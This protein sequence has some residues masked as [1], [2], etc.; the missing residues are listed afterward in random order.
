MKEI[1]SAFGSE[2]FRPLVT[3][4]LPGALAASSWVVACLWR[5]DSLRSLADANRA[6]SAA[7]VT[8]LAL[9]LG[10]ICED[11]GSHIEDAW[12]DKRTDERGDAKLHEDVWFRYLRQSFKIE[13]VGHRYLRSI[14]LRLKFELG[15]AV[16]CGFAGVGVWVTPANWDRTLALTLIGVGLI[17]FF[18]FEARCSHR[19]LRELRQELLEGIEGVSSVA[20][21]SEAASTRG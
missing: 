21:A 4:V 7:V 9:A 8:A 14:V 19:L 5:F 16:G 1:F 20:T 15:C 13:P 11:L 6:E 12:L 18:L 17:V 10:L 3:L 2:V